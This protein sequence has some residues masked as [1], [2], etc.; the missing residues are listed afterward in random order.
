MKRGRA[1]ERSIS[2]E[3]PSL[4][5]KGRIVRR[6]VRRSPTPEVELRK[7]EV[8]STA[9]DYEGK[10]EDKYSKHESIK[11]TEK[12]YG[13]DKYDQRSSHV[14]RKTEERLGGSGKSLGGDK[15]R[16]SDQGYT[17]RN[18]SSPGDISVR[19]RLSD[20]HHSHHFDYSLRVS[21]FDMK[22][23][24]AEVKT[25]LFRNFKQFGYINVKVL[26]YGKERH[27]F[28]NFTH[29]EDARKAREQMQDYL[30]HS[31]TLRVE[32]SKATLTKFPDLVSTPSSKRR[33]VS[34]EDTYEERPHS[35]VRGRETGGQLSTSDR[36]TRDVSYRGSSTVH[37]ASTPRSGT[38]HHHS[39]SG[40]I[41]AVEAKQV[42]PVLD[43]NATRTLFVG[44]LESDITERELRD[45][46][47]PYGR[48][49]CVDI[50]LQRSN[51]TAYAFVKF[52]TITDAI[53]AK[54]DMHGRQYGQYRLKIGFGRG[55][56]SAKV[57]I[58]NLTGYSDI[59]EVRHELDRFGLIRRVDYVNGDNHA[60]VH[61]DSLDAAQ[62]AVSSLN[63][64]TFHYR[65]SGK[66]LKIDLCRP[67][68]MRDDLDDFE[69]DLHV[70]SSSHP[71]DNRR[72][73]VDEASPTY[74]RRIRD[75][76]NSH[77]ESPGIATGS[78]RYQQKNYGGGG[79]VVNDSDQPRRILDRVAERDRMPSR[80]RPP[81]VEDS[82]EGG[83]YRQHS[84]DSELNT[85]TVY[86]PKRP[87]NGFD[88]YEYHNMHNRG[89]RNH[90]RARDH[91]PRQHAL[92]DRI[93][94]DR[95]EPMDTSNDRDARSSISGKRSGQDRE[96]DRDR[97]SNRDRDNRDKHPRD[98]EKRRSEE[99]EK[100]IP[101][102]EPERSSPPI[103]APDLMSSDTALKLGDATGPMSPD[104]DSK[105]VK[106]DSTTSPE[107]LA[108]LAKLFPI[109]WRG[110]L[111][112]KNTGFPSR[113]HL[114]GGDPAVAEVLLRSKDGK[115]DLSAL[116]ITQRLRLE[117]PRLEEVNKRMS[118]AGPGGHCILLALPAPTP[119]PS[120]PDQSGS[121]TTMQLR[122]L[123]SLV[124]YLKQKEAAG[125][126][127]LSANDGGDTV[128][129]KEAAAKDVIGVLHA[130]PPCPFSQTQLLKVA[131]T[132]G[133]E[134]SKEDHIVVLLVKGTV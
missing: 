73:Q 94:R 1:L 123:R 29:V 69:Q 3:L 85:E 24:D 79:R 46:F 80:K 89:A 102:K 8:R 92:R 132:L 77:P 74:K 2:D 114:V 50:K 81:P 78:Q 30:F 39:S 55:S 106:P 70:S 124:S 133:N 36:N 6:K 43:P 76:D 16:Q 60:F 126:V 83:G 12:Q 34:H 27:A 31:R 87:R 109:A 23:P 38:S 66:P 97:Y 121:D 14:S 82:Y 116:R 13:Y 45:L 91:A 100:T 84:R 68:H 47:G 120:S 57:W 17:S 44:N 33:T 88:A 49:E 58:G 99:P 117:P 93:S 62:S 32:W 61:F 98:L 112:L 65:S 48:I 104:S 111:V 118:T 28:I 122:P 107:T 108:D 5:P 26:G 56:P 41:G 64:S 119:C 51:F 63:E 20:Q 90:V 113:M 75:Y 10:Y 22:L 67:A 95:T 52:L 134:P 37:T 72:L 129:D 86:R 11:F 101:S 105:S 35:T 15:S 7:R 103:V 110:N 9:L 53:N 96:R 127:A 25:S 59:A 19:S 115:S 125:I 54:N 42:V 71:Y 18:H 21:N 130:F 4:A 40:S 131:S 128:P